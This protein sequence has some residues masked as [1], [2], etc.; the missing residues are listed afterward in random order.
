MATLDDD[1]LLAE[2]GKYGQ[3][4]VGKLEAALARDSFLYFVRAVAPFFV[5]EE[6]HVLIARAL[7]DVLAGKDDRLMIFLSPRSGKST[8]VNVLFP[9]WYYGHYPSDKVMTCSHSMDLAGRF[10]SLVQE[11]MKSPAYQRIFPASVPQKG[12]ERHWK[13]IQQPGKE[14]GE[15]VAAG[16]GKSI[17]GLGFNLGIGDD[18][19]SEQHAESQRMKDKAEFWY[20]N[21]FYTRRQLERNAIILVGTRWAFDDVP[22]RLLEEMRNNPKADKWRIISVPA[23]LDQPTADQVNEISGTDIL[24]SR[25]R[26]ELQAGESFA[27]RRFPMKELERSRATLTERSF[28][29]QYL[30][31]P[32]EDDGVILKRSRWRLWSKPELP[33]CSLIFQCWDT[34]IE[35]E[36]QNDYSACTTWG[37]FNSVAV[38]LD[39]REYEHAHIILLG[40][41]KGRVEAASLLYDRDA[42]GRIAPGPA[43]QLYEKFEP[44][45]VLV[46]KRASGHQLIQEMRRAGI[47]VKAWLPPG[48]QGAKSKVPRAHSASI[49]L[50]Q[51]CV[52]YPD[53]G[54]AEDV[55]AEAAQFPF[56]QYDDYT[57]TITMMLIY[58]RRHFHLMVPLDEPDS[59]EE[60]VEIEQHAFEESRSRRL[61]GRATGRRQDIISEALN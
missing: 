12:G 47:P 16:T 44:D 40:A 61:Y 37:L 2:I 32:A 27:P 24:V 19:I 53:R 50:G 14:P 51:G 52:W 21:G 30:Q 23:Y 31:K 5:V 41:W 25:Q 42:Q 11:L 55:I 45:Y 4:V 39:G 29:A 13:L 59:D 28:A 38:G 34:A 1:D 26:I 3:D 6:V 9:A 36:E 60:R 7:E 18:L 43:K 17:A 10:G 20:R 35:D 22:G 8:L 56:G 57:D 15:Y 33:K 49:P 58:L 46:E 54:W 48:P